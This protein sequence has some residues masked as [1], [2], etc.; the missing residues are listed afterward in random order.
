MDRTKSIFIFLFFV[1]VVGCATHKP[2]LKT[3]NFL[4]EILAH[5]TTIA[6]VELQSRYWSHE[7]YL[8]HFISNVNENNRNLAPIIYIH[9]LGGNLEDFSELIKLV[10]AGKNTRPFYAIDLPAFGKSFTSNADVSI[11]KYSEMLRDFISTLAIPKINLVCHSMGGQVCI[12]YALANS[13]KIKLLTLIDVAGV[14]QRSDYVN[15]TIH[16]HLGIN[17]GLVDLPGST[18]LGELV[19]YN[20]QFTRK[21]ITSNPLV[22]MAIESYKEN[23]HDRIHELKT[24]TLIIWGRD[25]KVFNFENGLYLKENIENASLYIIDNADHTPFASHAKFISTLIQNHL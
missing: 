9:G 11:Q 14:Y 3:E 1:V 15:Q 10:H 18:S 25:D 13:E 23:F 21:M 7:K 8:V 24:K 17:S 12:N 16:Q 20:Q 22:L 6:G 19:W 4:A 5:P 2:Q